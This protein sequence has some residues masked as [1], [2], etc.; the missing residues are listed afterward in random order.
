[1]EKQC[2][3]SSI[4]T[5]DKINS[6]NTYA[7]QLCTEGKLT[8]G[9]VILARNQT[10]G[11]GMQGNKWESQEGKNLTFSTILYHTDFP[12]DQQFMLSKAISLGIMDYLLGRANDFSIK[13]PNDIY[14]QNRKIAGILIE[15]SIQGSNLTESIVGIGLNLNQKYFS[16]EIRNPISLNTITG[17]EYNLTEELNSLLRFIDIRYTQLLDKSYDELNEIYL[18]NLYRYNEWHPFKKGEV[19]FT[20]RIIGVSPMGHLRVELKN[21]QHE[22][23]AF[24]D[25]EYMV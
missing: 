13:W 4:I 6:T 18:R 9:T 24:K 25:V 3:G 22:S 21:G 15:N 14:Y 7:T 5:L 1:M 11:K 17:E 2:I 12:A 16:Q 20:A 10:A 23:Y 19:V 8:S